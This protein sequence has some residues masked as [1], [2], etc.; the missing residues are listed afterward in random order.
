MP[1]R[2]IPSQIP[3][4]VSTSNAVADFY[5]LSLNQHLQTLPLGIAQ[6]KLPTGIS[7]DPNVI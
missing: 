4:I 1:S 3:L 2:T 6:E 7:R 5:I